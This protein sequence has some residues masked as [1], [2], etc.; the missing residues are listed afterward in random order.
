[1]IHHEHLC[2]AALVLLLACGVKIPC[3]EAEDWPGWM[4]PRRDNVLQGFD[5]LT[6]FHSPRPEVVW[7]TE[8]AGGYAGV[9]VA[10]GRL[11]LVDYVPPPASASTKH[12]SASDSGIER[13][14]CRHSETG[15]LIWQHEYP[16]KYTV[17]YPAGPR[18]TPTVDGD[19]LYTLGTEGDLHC[20]E[21]TTGTIVWSRQLPGDY[22]TK[23]ATW[24]YASHPLIDGEMI[25]CVVGG[26]G[27]HT[28]AFDKSTGQER[29]RHGTAPEQGYVPPTIIDAGGTRQLVIGR[30]DA[31]LAVNPETGAEYWRF[32]YEASFGS[33]I[34]SPALIRTADA[35]LLYFGG[36]NNKNLLLKLADDHPTAQWLWQDEHRKG[37]S[38]VNVQP[39]VVDDVMYGFDQGGELMAVQFPSG[40]RLWTTSKP[41]SER[42]QKSA[43]GF[44][45]RLGDSQ[46]FLM[47]AETGELMILTLQ[48]TGVEVKDRIALID[49]TGTA[50]GRKV[51]WSPPAYA[52]DSVYLRNDRE[53]IRVRLK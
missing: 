17:D 4:G 16:V 11:Y 45:V 47:F 33:I 3:A 14:Q 36:F 46:R 48:R 30:P 40:D 7:R 51:V 52:G 6:D 2:S 42:P 39:A 38:P 28:V 29:W 1:M 25:I 27:S 35:T 34:M 24:G 49:P 9:A 5:D 8:V 53:L 32:D 26:L 19:R 41:I 37:I 22:G 18:C 10:D 44:L 21:T 13:I 31:L 15:T 50:Y 23:T 12:P 20:L 43:T